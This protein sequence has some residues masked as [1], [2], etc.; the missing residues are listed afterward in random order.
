[1][2]PK[3]T[4]RKNYLI[5]KHVQLGLVKSFLLAIFISIAIL[6]LVIIAYYYI[7][8]MMGDNLFSE[9]IDINKRVK[10]ERVDIVDGV[11][12]TVEYWDIKTIPGV[13]RWELIW[14]PILV[15][16]IIIFIVISIIGVFYSHRMAGPVYRMK[17]DI[18][19]FRAGDKAKRIRLRD[20]DKFNDLA[21]EINALLDSFPAK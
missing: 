21:V 14:L 12:K 10:L 2:S 13:N 17:N 8:T 16:N 19:A 5:D 4:P 6:T 20:K 11:E 7:S 1:M 9:L 15:N 18:Q 3:Y